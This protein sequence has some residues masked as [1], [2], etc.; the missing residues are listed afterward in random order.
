MPV[1]ILLLPQKCQPQWPRHRL[2]VSA[3]C[4]CLYVAM[5]TH[6]DILCFLFAQIIP[7]L[8]IKTQIQTIPGGVWT[9][10]WTCTIQWQGTNSP[11]HAR[12][13]STALWTLA[14]RWVMKSEQHTV[15]GPRS[16]V[17]SIVPRI[18]PQPTS[19]ICKRERE[20]VWS[21]HYIIGRSSHRTIRNKS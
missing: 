19:Y 16:S 20:L 10:M 15:N 1:K 13:A 11:H 7:P 9:R 2:A 6:G 4:H 8:E 14:V 21:P 3:L 18:C 5:K 12:V 17:S